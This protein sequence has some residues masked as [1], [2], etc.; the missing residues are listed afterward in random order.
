MVLSA[1]LTTEVSPL[2]LIPWVA[3]TLALLEFGLRGA[4]W[5]VYVLGV[6]FILSAIGQAASHNAA[7]LSVVVLELLAVGLITAHLVVP[8]PRP[9]DPKG[10]GT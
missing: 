9:R 2:I 6:L 4:R 10:I 7:R 1:I 8:G 5:P 3:I